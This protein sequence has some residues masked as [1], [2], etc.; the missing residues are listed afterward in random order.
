M[1]GKQV[2]TKAAPPSADELRM[3]LLKREMEKLDQEKKKREIEQ[4]RLAD[5]AAEFIGNRV[6]DE[7]IA[8]VRRLV[9]N[10]AED[11]KFEAMVYSFPSVLCTD[12]G[13][14]INSAS[15]NWPETL[16]GKAKE[17]Y[18]RYE[19]IGKPAGYKLKAMIINF[20]GGVPGDVGFFLNWAPDRV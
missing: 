9:R 14:A 13:R 18:E 8:M 15:P 17:F 19:E 2:D 16:Q 20:P 5:F 1:S 12:E 11:G 3:A 10:A 4:K 6:S 7:E